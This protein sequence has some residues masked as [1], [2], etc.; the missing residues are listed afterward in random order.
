MTYREFRLNTEVGFYDMD[1][2][3]LDLG[4]D[5]NDIPKKT[6]EMM[7]KP[8]LIY[9]RIQ[10]RISI[11]HKIVMIGRMNRVNVNIDGVCNTTD[12]EVIKIVDCS[13]N[14]PMLLGLNW[15]FDN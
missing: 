14:Y 4:F 2:I 9:S 3:I 12:F 15:D 6:W 10:L 8:N 7:G 1:N 5:V 13:K 11:Q